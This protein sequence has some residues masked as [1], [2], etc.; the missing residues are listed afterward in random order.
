MLVWMVEFLTIMLLPP[1]ATTAVRTT[2]LF[3]MVAPSTTT[4]VLVPVETTPAPFPVKSL[5]PLPVSE[6]FG[7][8]NV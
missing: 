8:L 5:R 3:W 6:I 7:A 2:P 1:V 4:L